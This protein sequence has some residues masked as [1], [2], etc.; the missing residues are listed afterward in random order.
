MRTLVGVVADRGGGQCGAGRG[1]GLP[2]AAVY[3]RTSL[4]LRQVAPLLGV[5]RSAAGRI[6]E[7]LAGYLVLAPVTGRHPNDTVMS[8]RWRIAVADS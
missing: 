8:G 4:T 2:L 5:S 3:Y 6:V 1:W 7:H